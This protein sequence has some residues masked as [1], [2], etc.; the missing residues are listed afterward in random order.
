MSSSTDHRLDWLAQQL[1]RLVP[2]ARAPS[3]QQ[4]R[5]LRSIGDERAALAGLCAAAGLETPHWSPFA[6][7]SALPLLALR[8]QAGPAVV[9]AEAG[10]DAWLVQTEAGTQRLSRADLGQA[11]FSPLRAT[12]APDGPPTSARALFRRVLSAQR[13]AFVY[14]ALASLAANIAALAG[15]MY[16]MQVYDRVIPTRGLSTLTV[17]LIGALIACAF[18]LVIKQARAAVLESA[19]QRMDET[20]S[21]AIFQRL[22]ALRID[23]L[24]PNVGS[25]SAQL[26]GYESIRAF[27]IAATMYAVIDAPFGLLFLGVMALIGGPQLVAVPAVFFVVSVLAGSM[28]RAHIAAHAAGASIAGNRKVGLLVETISAAENIKAAGSGWSQSARWNAL[29]REAIDDDLKIKHLSETASHTAGF[30][31]QASY[32]VMIAAGAYIASAGEGL[33]SGGLI[34]CSILSGRVLGPI[35]LLP[36]LIV[37]WAH[38]RIALDNLERIFALEGDHH[39]VAQPLVPAR[40]EG[41][42]RIEDV[43]FAYPEQPHALALPLLQIAAGDKVAIVGPVGAGKSTLLKVMAGLYKPQ[44]GRV[45]IDGL[46]IQQIAREPLSA[47]LGYLPQEVRLVSGTLRD[48]LGLGLPDADDVTMLTACRATGLISLVTSHPKGLDLPI[49]EGG[50]GVSG[51]QRRLIGLT[52]LVL[53][54]PTVWLLDEPTSALDDTTER[55]S[56]ALLRE[57]MQPGQTLVVVTHRPQVLA[58]VDRIVVLT[59]GGIAL[60]GPREAVL[61]ALSQPARTAAPSP[62]GPSP[63]RASEAVA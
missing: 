21:H 24:P 29:T 56:L 61:Q 7:A 53:A 25:L 51:G 28:F 58:L 17:L 5:A 23:Q 15:S 13:A 20:L 10:S 1:P 48:N 43:K 2:Q 3:L 50:C 45:L 42:F 54:R 16:S 31:Q 55:Q 26:R 6:D 36:G 18:E 4:R 63:A 27:A 39:G 8:Q 44:Q 38:A 34:A 52:R 59:R 35:S 30:F 12:P 32:V 33:T 46:E 19:V 49:G 40:L 14:A 62:P 22:L 11:L 60:D 9:I 37:Q 41:H 57:A 47:Q